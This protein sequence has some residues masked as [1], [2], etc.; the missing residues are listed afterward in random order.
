MVKLSNLAREWGGMPGPSKTL[1]LSRKHRKIMKELAIGPKNKMQNIMPFCKN[2]RIN[3]VKSSQG[4]NTRFSRC[5]H[6]SLGREIPTNA[7]AITI[8]C[9]ETTYQS[10]KH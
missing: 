9:K 8:K 7:G 1:E 10:K 4:D 3:L 6:N 5:W 2:S